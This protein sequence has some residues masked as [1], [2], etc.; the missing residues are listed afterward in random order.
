MSYAIC[1]IACLIYH[2]ILFLM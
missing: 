1:F 2:F